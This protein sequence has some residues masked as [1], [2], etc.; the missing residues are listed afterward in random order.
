MR[1][2]A[3]LAEPDGQL[4]LDFEPP[5]VAMFTPAIDEKPMRM[6]LHADAAKQVDPPSEPQ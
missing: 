6:R 5:A 1:R 2:D 4:R 3:E